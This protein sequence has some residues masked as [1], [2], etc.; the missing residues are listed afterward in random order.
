MIQWFSTTEKDKFVSKLSTIG[1]EG[2]SLII[3]DE[4][5]QK[6]RGFGGCFNELGKIAI[7]E[8]SREEQNLVYDELF[9][10]EGCNFNFCRLSVGAN[11]FSEIWYSYD[12]YEGDFELEH[13][14]IDR[15]E[16]YIIP[17]VNEA[18]KRNSNIKF[19]ASPWSPPT[20]LKFP[21][22]YNYGKIIQEEK[23]LKAYA[24]YF[25]KYI[26]A[27]AER[28]IDIV[29]LHIQNEPA[30]SQ[31]FPSCRWNADE[32]INFISNYL[33]DAFR[34]NGI[35]SDIWLGTINAPC[36]DSDTLNGYHEYVGL[37]MDNAICR[38]TVK[39]ISFQWGGKAALQ[40]ARD[41]FP[42]LE[43]IQSESECGD[44]ENTWDYAMYI[45]D[46]LHHYFRNGVTAYV[47]WNMVLGINPESSWGWAQNSMITIANGKIVFNP[48]FYVMKH[49]SKYVQKG[50]EYI[51][52]K[53]RF[54]PY[55]VCFRNPNGEYVLVVMNCFNE[56]KTI[57]INNNMFEL[58]PRSFNTIIIK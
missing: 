11:D 3:T 52:L 33:A 27:Y 7:N 32:F 36:H 51:K 16:T 40:T 6:V 39:G 58:E 9:S 24:D 35:Q 17:Y 31:K 25:V 23:Y 8:L 26:K 10:E 18:L 4:A 48:E 14:S 42:E 22:V 46:L 13:F 20:W 34:N 30:S 21:R 1:Y 41:A 19:Y 15:D 29:Q 45:F 49:F 53:G 5:R 50:A 43:F 54:N 47:Y 44:G 28:N 56:K 57:N 37:V 12:E 38:D 2:I 55:S